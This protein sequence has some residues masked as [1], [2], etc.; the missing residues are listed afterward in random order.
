V[1]RTYVRYG[2]GMTSERLQSQILTALLDRHPSLIDIDQLPALLAEH[3]HDTRDT[4]EIDAA[5]TG[6]LGDGLATRLGD[7]VGASWVAV[8]A[9]RLN[10]R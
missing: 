7:L 4:G 1:I 5:L 10:A 6:L 9:T 3:G 8:R 2:G